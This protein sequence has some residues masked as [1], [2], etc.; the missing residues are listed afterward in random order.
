MAYS[1][2]FIDIDAE[3]EMAGLDKITI[4]QI[5]LRQIQRCTDILSKERTGGQMIERVIKGK[6]QIIQTPDVRAEI[7]RSVST[8]RYI[9]IPFYKDKLKE[10]FKKV[11]DEM[12]KIKDELDNTIIKIGNKTNKAKEFQFIPPEHP[13]IKIKMELKCDN[14][15]KL[16]GVLIRAYHKS[17]MDLRAYEI[18]G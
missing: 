15:E 10:E 5:V 9:L 18:D 1:D 2:E 8:L 3:K 13:I 11:D 17:Q 12:K 4:E 16:F 6:K 14:Y 7:I